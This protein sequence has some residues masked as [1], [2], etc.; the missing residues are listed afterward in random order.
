MQSKVCSLDDLLSG[1]IRYLV[2]PYQR[3]YVWGRQQ[4]E[5]L[6]SDIHDHYFAVLEA[7]R[8]GRDID[9]YLGPII[10]MQ[11][12]RS[13]MQHEE[14]HVVDGQQRLITLMVLLS[15]MKYY[16]IQEKTDAFLAGFIDNALVIK[17][18]EETLHRIIPSKKD[19]HVYNEILSHGKIHDNQ[20]SPIFHAYRSYK[21]WISHDN[22]II[23]DLSGLFKVIMTKMNLV[24]ISLDQSENPYLVFESVN[25][26]GEDL[27]ESDLVKN[28]FFSKYPSPVEADEMYSTYWEP[29][30]E[31]FSRDSDDLS[32]FLRH[33]YMKNGEIIEKRKIFSTIRGLFED[34]SPDEIRDIT[35]NLSRFSTYYQKILYPHQYPGWKPEGIIKHLIRIQNLNTESPY[36]F[37]LHCLDQNDDIPGRGKILS[38][39]EL[40]N[41]LEVIESYLV[42]RFVCQ[43]KTHTLYR[44]FSEL[45]PR[46]ETERIPLNAHELA[47]RINT[48]Q[49]ADPPADGE[50]LEYLVQED[51]YRKGTALTAIKVVLAGLEDSLREKFKK[52]YPDVSQDEWP[53]QNKKF[54]DF[55]IDP[56]MPEVLTAEWKHQLGEE[57]A[58]I[59]AENYKKLGNLTLSLRKQ[60]LLTANSFS[61]KKTVYRSEQF[62]L[63]S[64]L[65]DETSWQEEEIRERTGNLA[66]LAVKTWPWKGITGGEK[67][68][69]GD[70]PDTQPTAIIV[71]DRKYP[72]KY[73]Y[74]VAERTIEAASEIAGGDVTVIDLILQSRDESDDVPHASLIRR[75]SKDSN[76]FRYKIGN[77]SQYSFNSKNL[78]K[79]E[80]RNVARLVIEEMGW[81]WNLVWS[82]SFDVVA[83]D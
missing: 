77:P 52:E 30:E 45:C 36:P 67:W 24:V 16:A 2:P 74:Q 60:A 83:P 34:L 1:E 18:G 42:R 14:W 4:W 81:D 17:K 54:Q 11:N 35:K 19:V 21:L 44:V 57:Y 25:S 48:M 76:K 53:H 70:L 39:D 15:V 41:I 82:L 72:V 3:Q 61:D 29:M 79:Y 59:Q 65:L 50:F 64:S 13:D 63:D 80:A 38:D 55:F 51:L 43:K 73:W 6:W 78:G 12:P 7:E 8:I 49:K 32:G 69:Y 27:T 47:H 9:Y 23:S 71:R 40:E 68:L 56:I 20:D 10:L 28:L 75:F 26:K 5:Q 62:L 46:D 31:R 66:A 22:T 37:L 58:K 33:Y